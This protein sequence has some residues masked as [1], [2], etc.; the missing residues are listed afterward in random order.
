VCLGQ[1]GVLFQGS[2]EFYFCFF[3]FALLHQ[4]NTGIIQRDA[5]ARVLAGFELLS[6]AKASVPKNNKAD[7]MDKSPISVLS[8]KSTSDG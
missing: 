6:A 1:I 4:F 5:G 8:N 7:H 3:V 2:L